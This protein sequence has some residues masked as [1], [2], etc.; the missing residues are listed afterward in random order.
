MKSDHPIRVQISYPELEADGTRSNDL[1]IWMIEN[2]GLTG[3]RYKFH[4]ELFYM[5]YSFRDEK[6]AILFA[7]RWGGRVQKIELVE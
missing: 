4:P 3:D 6:D 2:F 5:I 7:L 1:H